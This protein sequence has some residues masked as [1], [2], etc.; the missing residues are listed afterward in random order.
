MALRLNNVKTLAVQVHD[1]SFQLRTTRPSLQEQV[2]LLN[3][4]SF[5]ADKIISQVNLYE[6]KLYSKEQ[7]K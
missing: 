1:L 3:K 5:L 2:D 6:E 4:I 7:A